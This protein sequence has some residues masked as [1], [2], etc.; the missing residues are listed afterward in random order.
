MMRLLCDMSMQR[1]LRM[2]IILL[3]VLTVACKPKLA[4]PAFLIGVSQDNSDVWHDK[5]RDEIVHEAVFHPEISL[6]LT[7]AYGHTEHQAA[8]IDSLVE[9]GVDLL[10]VG[11]ENPI[12]VKEA[13]D[14][15]FDAG[16]PVVIKEA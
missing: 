4:E 16:I 12:T 8:Q 6:V 3:A 15:A 5:M 13:T 10:I 14:R 11:V 2:C 9:A 1:M 7:N